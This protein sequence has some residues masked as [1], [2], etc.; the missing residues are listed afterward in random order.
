M[1]LRMWQKKGQMWRR[2]GTYAAWS[3]LGS[4]SPGMQP[5]LSQTSHCDILFIVF[6]PNFLGKKQEETFRTYPLP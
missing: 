6:R 1:P 2:E 5:W 3:S 4:L